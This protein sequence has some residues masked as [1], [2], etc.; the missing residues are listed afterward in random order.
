MVIS[1]EDRAFIIDEG[2][3]ISGFLAMLIGLAWLF[4]M[5]WPRLSPPANPYDDSIPP[6]AL[7]APAMSVP[8]GLIGLRSRLQICRLGG[9]FG[10]VV[11]LAMIVVALI[12][13]ERQILPY[14]FR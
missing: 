4:W 14:W 13:N 10:L 9:W 3:N 6:M 2:R 7:I 8:L 1:R 11:P 5:C 12:G